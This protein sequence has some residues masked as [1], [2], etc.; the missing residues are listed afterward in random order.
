M[1]NHSPTRFAGL[2]LASFTVLATPV[3]AGID[4]AQAQTVAKTLDRSKPMNLFEAIFPKLHQQ[5]L[6]K[7][8]LSPLGTSEP[9]EIQKV[10]A[11][12]YYTYRPAAL[13]KVDLSRVVPATVPSV[14]PAAITIQAPATGE[15]GT[16]VS[17]DA[18]P[19]ALPAPDPAAEAWSAVG[20]ELDQITVMAEPDIAK[21]V[22]EFYANRPQLLWTTADG[23]PNAWAR[24]VLPV[25]G[26]AARVGLDPQEYRVELPVADPQRPL[27]DAAR[28]EIEMTARVVRYAMDAMGGRINPNKLSGYHDFPENRTNATKVLER[29]IAGRLPAPTLAGFNPPSKEFK[30]L[31]DELQALEK[32]ADE[33]IDIPADTLVKPGEKHEQVANIV[34]A[35]SRK[36]SQELKTAHANVLD[37]PAGSEPLDTFTPEVV[38][39]VKAFQKE[40]GLTPDG[41]VGRNTISRLVGVSVES[42]REMVRLAMERLRWHPAEL[43]QRRVFVN[44]PAFTATYFNG[45]KPQLARRAVVGTKANQTSFFYDTIETVEYNPY[46]GV[47]RSILVNEFLPKLRANPAYLDERGYEVTDSKGK[48]V[49]SSAIDWNQVGS[50]PAFDVRQSPGEAN[51]LGEL[52]ILFP[53][54]HAIYM[55]DTPARNLFSRDSRA[56]SHGCIRL[57][58]PREMAAAVLGKDVGYIGTRLGQGHGSDE[59]GGRIPVYVAY[60]TAWPDA[61]GKVEYFADVY[62]RDEALAKAISATRVVRVPTS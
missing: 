53:N 56:Y 33:A 11:P 15:A 23:Q 17:P 32:A 6:E 7:E 57:H 10:S 18:S 30:A 47:P 14:E 50:N 35:I 24:S 5:R 41:V 9:V 48:R 29:L 19:S 31:V 52:K 12:K 60:F 42:R 39:L 46:W 27:N 20:A 1:R 21:A 36:V 25:L 13:V 61:D 22:T 54:K 40:A 62:G 2:M 26:D 3:I 45:G 8:G 34:M 51:A 58:K 59:V 44:Q 4:L 38:D 49:A 37:R 16:T 28:F 43:G 55:H